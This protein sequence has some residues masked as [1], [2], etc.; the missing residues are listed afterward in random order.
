MALT[1]S[2]PIPLLDWPRRSESS[3]RGELR[4][5]FAIASANPAFSP[6][7]TAFITL[8]TAHPA[9][10]D[11]AVQKALP[12]S[13]FPAFN[14]A[15]DVM[16]AELAQLEGLEKRV[17]RVKGEQGVRELVERLAFESREATPVDGAGG[18]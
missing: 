18:L 8:S 1:L 10:F 9:K 16:P 14:F 6:V 13:E 7:T 2:I 11:A 15:G 5:P 3:R 17:T 12:Q 4:I